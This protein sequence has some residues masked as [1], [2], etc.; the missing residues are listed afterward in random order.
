MAT[1]ARVSWIGPGLRLVASGS[2]GTAI[3]VDH[4]QPDEQRTETGPRPMELLLIG[5]A[6]CT[7]M[8][9]F[10][11]LKK[12]RQAVTGLDVEVTAERAEEHPRV[13]TEIHL[14][15]IVRGKGVEAAAVERSIELSQTKYCGATAML[16]KSASISTSF[17]LVDD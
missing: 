3:V 11:I 4:V 12:K 13:Y 2:Q 14:Q 6:G 16:S 5:L 1:N 9:V 17:R 15:F 10:S 8:D 7:A